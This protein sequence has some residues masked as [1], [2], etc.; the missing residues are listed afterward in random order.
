MFNIQ[1]VYHLEDSELDNIIKQVYKRPF[2]FQQQAG[3]KERGIEKFSVPDAWTGDF[4]NYEL[5]EVVNHAE[6]GVSFAA[7]LK[8][9]PTQ[10]IKGGSKDAT[11]MWWERNFYPSTQMVLNDLHDRG[12]IPSGEYVVSI[13]W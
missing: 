13:D 1:S 4:D 5:P 12:L 11:I 2:N 8:R 6:V 9:D 7:W 3:C 10:L